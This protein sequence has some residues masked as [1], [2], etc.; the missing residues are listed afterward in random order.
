MERS[1]VPQVSKTSQIEDDQ[2]DDELLTVQGIEDSFAHFSKFGLGNRMMDATTITQSNK[3]IFNHL[4]SQQANLLNEVEK[5]EE[6]KTARI[7]ENSRLMS[8]MPHETLSGETTKIN[9][10]MKMNESSI[11]TTFIDSSVLSLTMSE[12]AMGNETIM[13]AIRDPFDHEVKTRLLNRG[14]ISQLAQ[15]PNYKHVATVTPK[16][17]PKTVIDLQDRQKYTVLSE[18]GNGSFANIFLIQKVIDKK[19]V[20]ALKVLV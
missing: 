20:I 14:A 5:Q 9:K 17:T 16:V 7:L 8:E 10:L 13:N 11:E 19:C 6:E 4:S 12:N 1:N 2:D 18:I 15:N 3:S